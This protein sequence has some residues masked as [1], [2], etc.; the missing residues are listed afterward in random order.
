MREGAS[1]TTILHGSCANS[2]HDG[3]ALHVMDVAHT[4]VVHHHHGWQSP[5]IGQPLQG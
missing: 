1:V 5:N 2:I 3:G 4:I